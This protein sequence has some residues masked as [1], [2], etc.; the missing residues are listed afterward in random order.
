[1]KYHEEFERKIKGSKIEVADD[2]ES[3]R[4][5][6]LGSL[7]SQFEYK[8]STSSDSD[9]ARRSSLTHTLPQSAALHSMILDLLT[10]FL[11]FFRPRRLVA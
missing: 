2:P 3:K 8:R 5:K 7:V 1:V 11:L 6:R 9:T 4:L 10:F